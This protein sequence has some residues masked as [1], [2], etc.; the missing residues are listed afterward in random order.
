MIVPSDNSVR[1]R[2]RTALVP[3]ATLVPPTIMAEGELRG[4]F[5]AALMGGI[6]RI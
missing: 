5:T 4:T 3:D 1:G 6:Q 2:S